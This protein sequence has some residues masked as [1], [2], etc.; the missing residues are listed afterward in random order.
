MSEQLGN[1]PAPRKH[2]LRR[3]LGERLECEAAFVEA[4]VRH[5]ESRE[6]DDLVCEDEQVEVDGSRA[7]PRTVSHASKRLLDTEERIEKLAGSERR[8]DGDRTVHEPRL[9]DDT[10]RIRLAKAGYGNHIDASF[11]VEQLDRTT[12]RLLPL[13]EVGAEPDVRQRH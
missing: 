5:A 1:R 9:I 3:K 10:N 12:K 7:P 11:G 13:A 8:L 4:W 6:V 2:E